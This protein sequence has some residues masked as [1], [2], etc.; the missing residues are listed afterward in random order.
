[1][2]LSTP[3]Y[4]ICIIIQFIFMFCD[5]I[6]NC[7]S[8]F[9]RTKDALLVLFIFQD[10]FLV[11][12]ITAMLMTFFSTYLFQRCWCASSARRARCARRTRRPACCCMRCGCSSSGTSRARRRD[13]RSYSCSWSR[14]ACPP[15]TTSSTNEQL[16]ALVILASMK[17]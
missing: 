8:L 11:L 14:D 15:G 2:K 6:F 16:C 12:S 9:P 1:M 17:T 3:K 13:Q 5:L 7:V 10:L 4:T